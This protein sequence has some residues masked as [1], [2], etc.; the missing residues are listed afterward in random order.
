MKFNVSSADL[1]DRVQTIS[2][3]IA[4]KNTLEIMSD[5]LFT[6]KDQQLTLT[7]SD[8]E[9]TIVTTLPLNSSEGQISV[10][11]DTKR[12]TD[13][14]RE[15]AD[16]PLDIEVDD[17]NFQVRITTASGNYNLGGVNGSEYPE[18]SMVQNPTAQFPIPSST[19]LDAITKTIFAAPDD[20]L[21]PVMAGIF[22]DNNDSGINFVAT[23]AHKLV[24]YRVEDNSC[25][26]GN[27]FILARKPAIILQSL[28]SK[29]NDNVSIQYDDKMMQFSLLNYTMY[30]RQVE[31]K[32]PNYDAVIP[33]NNPFTLSIDRL[34]AMAAL[35]RTSLYSAEASNM[36]K[37]D[38]SNDRVVLSAQDFEKSVSATETVACQYSGD[39]LSIGFKASYLIEIFKN[40]ESDNVLLQIADPNRAA[41]ILPETNKQGED[42]LMLL[43]PMILDY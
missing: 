35:R 9:T 40:I 14:L 25:P 36:V 15:F 27:S 7:A 32:Y 8:L 37:L 43:M 3:V 4:S 16:Q 30:S 41:I 1:L 13:S 24:R 29:D 20:K 21:R 39:P 28:L 17:Q 2:R 23:D 5:I 31:G 11:I 26:A 18:L 38:I 22:V 12:L 33:K 10:A 42:I 34:A 6:V 19:L